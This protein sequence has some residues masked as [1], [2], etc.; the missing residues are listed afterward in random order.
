MGVGFYMLCFS[1]LLLQNKQV[2]IIGVSHRNLSRSG[3]KQKGR[4][5]GKG[6]AAFW[7]HVNSCMCTRV[8]VPS[9]PDLSCTSSPLS[10]F[11]N[12]VPRV[13]KCRH[14]MMS[15]F[16]TQCHQQDGGPSWCPQEAAREAGRCS[17]VFIHQTLSQQL[18][19]K[20]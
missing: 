17:P 13:W 3:V 14:D 16:G 1:F 6:R 8:A 11:Q 9:C 18:N 10:S 4:S 12:V 7:Q 2:R 15:R 5:R 20:C 19:V